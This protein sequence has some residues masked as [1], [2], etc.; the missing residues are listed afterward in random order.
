VTALP[1]VV[2]DHPS[3]VYPVR[4]RVPTPGRVTAVP[5]TVKELDEG[6]LPPVLLLPL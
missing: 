3:N 4:T 5:P 2:I 6:A 1:E